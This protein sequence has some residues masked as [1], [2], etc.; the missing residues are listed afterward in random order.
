MPARALAE[1]FPWRD[2][3]S[4]IDIGAAQ[5]CVPVVLAQAHPHLT[6]GGFD[7][8]VVEPAFNRYVGRHGL[9]DR[10]KFH[11]GDFFHDPLPCADVLVMGRILHNWDLDTKKALL[12]KAYARIAARRRTHRVRDV[13]RRCAAGPVAQPAR[14]PEH[15]DSNRGGL[16]VYW[17]GMYRLDA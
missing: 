16:R 17:R 12:A 11:G 8:P 1:W 13:D 5:G 3:A 6:G 15:G 14:E 9:A 10:L 7:L 2:Y 4:V